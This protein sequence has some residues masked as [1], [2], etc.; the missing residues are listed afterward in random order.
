MKISLFLFVLLVLAAP[1][2]FAQRG[3]PLTQFAGQS[4]DQMIAEF[5]KEHQI[6]GMTLSI[7]QAPYVSRVIGYG[8]A[9]VERGLLAAPNT[10]WGRWGR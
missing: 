3:N 8:V 2:A 5:M 4:P 9:D 7:V 6:P 10:L 1:M